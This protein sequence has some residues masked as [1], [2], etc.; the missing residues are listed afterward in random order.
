MQK[1]NLIP[2]VIK[3]E[4]KK[5]KNLI[6]PILVLIEFKFAYFLRKQKQ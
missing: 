6:N 1:R 2:N 5:N 4:N 3:N